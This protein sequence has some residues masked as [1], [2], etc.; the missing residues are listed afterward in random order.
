MSGDRPRHRRGFAFGGFVLLT[1][2]LLLL[3]GVGQLPEGFWFALLPLWPVLVI[4]PGINLIV[5]R[6]NVV[7]GS[8]AALAALVA[9]V[10]AAWVMAPTGW[11]TTTY[12]SQQTV[13]ASAADQTRIKLELPVGEL[14]LFG[15]GDRSLAVEGEYGLRLRD[16]R[17]GVTSRVV[18]DRLEID[19]ESPLTHRDLEF[20]ALNLPGDVWEEWELGVNPE[21]DT[22][23]VYEGGVG[24]LNLDLSDLQV[25]D[26]DV[27]VGVAEL[28]LVLPEAGRSEISLEA[29]VGDMN[30]VIPEGLAARIRIRGGVAAVDIDGSRFALYSQYGDGFWIFGHDREYRTAD[31]S[32]SANRV[33]LRIEIG[34]GQIRI[35]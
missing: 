4:A 25:T 6:V 22:R 2:V 3:G 24:R 26:V 35:R 14:K 7:L 28:N 31:W 12:V 1:G 13:P 5:S 11:D 15:G 16:Q 10:V 20:G 32:T 9:V 17:V 8:A 29:G 21:V 18:A 34:V 30:V 27:R 23:V 33:D 19:I